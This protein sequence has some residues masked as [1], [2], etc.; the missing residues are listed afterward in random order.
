MFD[1]SRSYQIYSF[2]C[3]DKYQTSLSLHFFLY[4]VSQF[5]FLPSSYLPFLFPS[6]ST[7]LFIVYL[8]SEVAAARADESQ[9]I[10]GGTVSIG[11]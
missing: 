8:Q 5:F 3:R 11:T 10:N 4:A 2:F 1:F 9:R 7:C 6:S